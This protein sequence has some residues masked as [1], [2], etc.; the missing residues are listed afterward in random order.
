MLDFKLHVIQGIRVATERERER[1][2]ER[3]RERELIV[4]QTL[5]FSKK[6]RGER[7]K[8]IMSGYP[9]YTGNQVGGGSH[10]VE[11]GQNPRTS[12][13][14]PPGV[15]AYG[16]GGQQSYGYGGGYGQ[17]QQNQG[18]A[19]SYGQAGPQKPYNPYGAQAGGKAQYQQPQY[20]GYGA[21]QTGGGYT[22]PPVQQPP[23][24]P[25]TSQYIQNVSVTSSSFF[26]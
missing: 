6:E 18:G 4:I 12:Q 25:P 2:K 11:M 21:Q 5:S 14:Q 19:A 10:D 16:G 1:E 8:S 26:S 17:P 24:R 22:A 20:A 15:V 23:P 3:E 7:D 13:L 9:G